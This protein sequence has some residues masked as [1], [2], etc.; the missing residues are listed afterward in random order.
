MGQICTARLHIWKMMSFFVREDQSH[1][2]KRKEP[3]MVIPIIEG[4]DG[5]NPHSAARLHIWRMMSFYARE[6]IKY[7]VTIKGKDP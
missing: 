4:T 3:L 5:P 7:P 6:K 1:G 2:Y